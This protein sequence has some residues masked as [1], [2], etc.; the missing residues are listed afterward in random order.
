MA[1]MITHAAVGTAAAIAFA[2]SGVPAQFWPVAILSATIADADAI[3]FLIPGRL[4]DLWRHRGFFHS[5]FFGVLLSFFWL[6]VFFRDT[7]VFSGKWFFYFNFFFLVFCSHGFLDALTKGGYGVS[8][9]A[10]FD[11]TRYSFPWSPI[12]VSPIR[13]SSFFSP[14]GLAVMKNEMRCVWIPSFSIAIFFKLLRLLI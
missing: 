8:F 6:A 3:S 1:S 9:F 4:D 5:L 13:L 14:W 2:P 11:N 7:E 10:P 12:L